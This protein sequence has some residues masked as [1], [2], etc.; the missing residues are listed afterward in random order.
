MYLVDMLHWGINWDKPELEVRLKDEKYETGETV[1]SEHVE[2]MQYTGIKDKKGREI[3]EGDILEAWD[4]GRKA[5][6]EVRYRNE[7][8]P[9]FILWPAYQHGEFWNL[10]GPHD[11]SALVI[12]NIYEHS[13]R[14]VKKEQ[15]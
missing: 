7:G 15:I 3:Y 13:E 8:A 6:F 5:S 9:M 12:G 10:H 1:L 4:N 11:T 2:L 14:L